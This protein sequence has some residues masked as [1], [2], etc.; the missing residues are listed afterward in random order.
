[1]AH[2]VILSGAKDLAVRQAHALVRSKHEDF[3]TEAQRAQRNTEKSV[4]YALGVRTFISV[5]LCASVVNLPLPHP[6]N[7]KHT[8]TGRHL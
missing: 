7:H 3:T 4:T 6:A 2:R 5:F 8:T 1:M